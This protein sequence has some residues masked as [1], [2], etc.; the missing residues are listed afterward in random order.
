[1]KNKRVNGRT[2]TRQIDLDVSIPDEMSDEEL[3]DYED[4]LLQEEKD[5]DDEYEIYKV[6]PT[7]FVEDINFEVVVTPEV[8][9]R[10]S[11]EIEKGFDLAIYD[12]AKADPNLDQRMIVRDFL[13]S[14]NKKS[15]DNP[16]KYILKKQP[17]QQEQPI[18]NANMNGIGNIMAEVQ[19]NSGSGM[20]KAPKSPV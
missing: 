4:S 17:M 16:D 5:K 10:T 20:P 3:N 18:Q 15:K 13:L 6:N 11:E 1:M 12:R 19:Q 14:T 7:K 9:N 8:M 2:V